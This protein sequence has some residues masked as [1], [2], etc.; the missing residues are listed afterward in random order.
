[1]NPSTSGPS[2]PRAA[3]KASAPHP[4]WP[5]LTAAARTARQAAAAAR[6]DAAP[7]GFSTRVVARWRQVR[8]EE[9][10]LALWQRVSWRA[11]FAS[12]ALGAMV[13]VSQG[14]GAGAADH[15]LLEPPSFNL[16]GW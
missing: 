12:L 16:P 13:V 4:A 15:P 10:R 3:G 2:I 11:A 14:G 5:R 8:E 7:Y 1:M 9:Q 6:D